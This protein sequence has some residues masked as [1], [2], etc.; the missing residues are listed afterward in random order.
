MMDSKSV[1]LRRNENETFD[2]NKIV[3]CF[4]LY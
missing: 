4:E 3:I 2:G 1:S